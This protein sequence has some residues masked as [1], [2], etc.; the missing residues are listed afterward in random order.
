MIYW[1]F[2]NQLIECALW[3]FLNLQTLS[4]TSKSLDPAPECMIHAERNINVWAERRSLVGDWHFCEYKPLTARET[5]DQEGS[6]DWEQ[7]DLGTARVLSVAY[8]SRHEQNKRFLRKLLEWKV[9]RNG[10][11]VE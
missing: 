8:S 3:E 7:T 6:I 5:V 4:Q 11:H 10:D 9:G 2:D 1:L